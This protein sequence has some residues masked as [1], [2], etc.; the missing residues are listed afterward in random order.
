M[1]FVGA[2]QLQ[3]RSQFCSPTVQLQYANFFSS[4]LWLC[5]CE[6][7]SQHNYLYFFIR[8]TPHY[9][10][11]HHFASNVHYFCRVCKYDHDGKS[12]LCD[13]SILVMVLL[14]PHQV[15]SLTEDTRQNLWFGFKEAIQN[16]LLPYNSTRQTT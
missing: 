14:V 15:S 7:S 5:S 11:W 1:F 10:M 2:Y 4:T 9:G 13:L 16:K 6:N 12:C 8:E 3:T